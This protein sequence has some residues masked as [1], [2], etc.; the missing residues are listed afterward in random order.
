MMGACPEK[1]PLRCASVGVNAAVFASPP[2][3]LNHWELPKKNN[4]SLITGTP[5][6]KPN[7]FWLRKAFSGRKKLLAAK[8]L[9][10]LNSHRLP[11]ILLVPDFVITFMIPPG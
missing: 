4:L 7:W 8:A 2:Q 5:T 1:S 9:F 10:R 3:T 6:V 11:W